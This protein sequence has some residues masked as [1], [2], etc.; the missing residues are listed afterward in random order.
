MSTIHFYVT[1]S[2]STNNHGGKRPGAG[3]KKEGK[4]VLYIRVTPESAERIRA[5]AKE[6][7]CSLGEAV[8]ILM[9]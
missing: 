7:R 6:Q 9:R 5:V 1:C 2:M 3:R 4:E 8:E